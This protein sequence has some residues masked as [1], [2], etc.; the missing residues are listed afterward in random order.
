MGENFLTGTLPASL[1]NLTTCQI[2]FLGRNLLR[3]TVPDGMEALQELTELALANN[4]LSGSIPSAFGQLRGLSTLLLGYN[5]F[6]GSL[7]GVFNASAQLQLASVQVNNNQLTGALPAE[8]F[9]L[10]AL[11]TGRELSNCFQGSIPEAACNASALSTL[12]LDGLSSSTSCRRELPSG[13]YLLSRSVGGTLP[14]CLFQLPSLVTLHLSGNVFTGPV[15]EAAL[16]LMANLSDLSVSHNQLTGTIPA[17]FQTRTWYNLDL[18]YNRLSGSLSSAFGSVGVIPNQ[19]AVSLENNRLSGRIPGFLQQ[20]QNVSVLGTNLFEC[21]LAGSDLPQHDSDRDN[22]QCGSSSFNVPFYLWLGLAALTVVLPLWGWGFKRAPKQHRTV[23]ALITTWYES[24][25]RKVDEK[26]VLSNLL[27]ALEQLCGVAAY[28]AVYVTVVLLPCYLLL[29]HYYGTLTH[30]Y[31]W[32]VSAA[33]LSG[34]VPVAVELPLLLLLLIVVLCAMHRAVS[35]T[36]IPT[37]PATPTVTSGTEAIRNRAV[38]CALFVII[39][40]VVVVGVNMLYVY[41]AIYQ[42]SALLVLAQVLMSFFKLL[43]SSNCMDAMLHW[44]V[45]KLAPE[46]LTDVSYAK[47]YRAQFL[48]LQL[49]VSLLNSIAIPC[50]VVAGISPN[51]FYNVFQAA[52]V[53]R[54]QYIVE[55]CSEQLVG[56]VCFQYT[57]LE[58]FT[59]Y[60]A[61]YTYNYQCSSSLITYYAPAYINLCIA[62]AFASPLASVLGVFGLKHAHS[63]TA[64][65]RAVRYFTP[66]IVAPP[67]MTKDG[68]DTILN[69]NQL[70]VTLVTYLGV[71]LTFGTML[72]PLGVALAATVAMVVLFTKLKIGRFLCSA[73]EHGQLDKFVRIL[74]QQ[75][76]GA[77]SASFLQSALWMLV[78]L[79]CLFYALFLFDTLGDA[80]EFRRAMW[81]LIVVPLLPL[82]LYFLPLVIAHGSRFSC[83]NGSQRK[84]VGTRADIELGAVR[85]SGQ[86]AGASVQEGETLN[87]LVLSSTSAE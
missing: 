73:E 85:E 36:T 66:R 58:Y 49:G 31:A 82:C 77:G 39:D 35:E 23:A 44:L 72:P 15:P 59:E 71:L 17:A 41:I 1:V 62:A 74:E 16:P 18:S 79:S 19:S 50:L 84:G 11:Q 21:N 81:V 12:V 14:Q 7:E 70:L 78:T 86:G 43:W 8:V 61:P 83:S 5:Q 30:S 46:L 54:A 75:C 80:V 64:I 10:P 76:E 3:G 60:D 22:Y 69:A 56:G 24:S 37:P 34:A 67:E 4:L 13:A 52:S 87:A 9:Q 45:A 2:L 6:S 28:C 55:D 42:S 68:A 63:S 32:T 53:V 20:M 26:T 65:Y 40:L 51:C 29:S 25:Q 38:I 33:F 48:S 27:S 57:P 47:A